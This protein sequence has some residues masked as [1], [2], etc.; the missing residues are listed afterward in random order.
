VSIRSER[1]TE[2]VRQQITII[3]REDLTD[4]RIGEVT[5]TRVNLSKDLSVAQVYWS[6]FDTDAEALGESEAGLISAAGYVR[7]LLAQRL[8]LRRT[9]AI[10]FRCDLSIGAG[11]RTLAVLRELDIRPAI[12]EQD[13]PDET[14]PNDVAA[15]RRAGP[16]TDT[17]GENEDGQPT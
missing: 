12:P 16:S 15:D 2:Q 5:V 17:N 6:A 7:K 4:P 3:L 1:I 8:D 10:D 14:A 13:T 9:P 11:D